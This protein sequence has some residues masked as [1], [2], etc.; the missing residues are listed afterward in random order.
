MTTASARMTAT[1]QPGD[2]TEICVVRHGETD[3]NLTGV[4]QGWIDVPLNENGRRQAYE[5]AESF[6]GSGF[7]CV[8]TSPLRR[9]A[10]TAEIVAD[11]LGLGSPIGSDGLKE[12]HFGAI[13]GMTKQDLSLLHPGLH[14]CIVRRDPACRFD[15]GESLDDFADRVMQAV[16]AMAQRHAGERILAMTHG[17]VMDVITRHVAQL[18]RSQVLNLKRKNGESLWLDVTAGGA[19]CMHPGLP[20]CQTNGAE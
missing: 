17:W 6:K 19:V 14:E 20:L 3:W 12:R 18:A 10:E 1:N 2:P 16:D 5:M 15:D 8:W 4:L 9:A 13:Q 7:S 11:V